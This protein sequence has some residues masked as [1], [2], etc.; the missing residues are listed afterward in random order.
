VTLLRTTSRRTFASLR[1]H[2]NYRLFFAG[3]LT[4]VA[5]TWMQNIAL[6]WLV[7]QLSPHSRGLA[8]ALLTVC[9]FG[10]FTILGLFAGVVTDRLDNRKTVIVTQIVQMVFSA[11]LAAITLLGHT[12]L[13][14][15][16]AI[17]ALTGTAVVFDTPSR[18]NLTFQMVGRDELPNAIALNSSLFNTAR[19]FGP[20]LAG[21]LIAAVGVGWCFAINAASFLAVLAA[22]LAMRTA[23]L[24]PLVD[25]RRP[26][27]WRGTREGLRYARKNRTVFVT[28]SMMVVFASICFNFNI[29]L[30]LLAKNTL[31]AG[32][33]TFGVI[34]AAFGAGAL[35]GA[36][37]AATIANTRWRFMLLGAAG[38]GACELFIAPVHGVALAAALLFV[39]GAF[40]TSYTANS[41]SAIQLASPDHIRGR[42][43]GLYYYAW[44][45]L[46]P[47]GAIIVGWLCD[48]GGTELAFAV[49]GSV[50]LAMTLFGAAAVTRM[51]R[52]VM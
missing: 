34:S 43:L 8:V 10:P 44:N 33:R 17:A 7:L 24:F 11:V 12:Q 28:L 51:R 21:V 3:Q 9:R 48:R 4:S 37:S 16:Y 1:H 39:C 42:V 46:A 49:G 25:R 20:A 19:I 29:L 36:L 30:P 13:W 6:A 22:L 15:V 31:D 35:L 27:M 2:Y 14:E 18:Q 40:F 23:E 32:P 41:N 45:G 38:F 47:F 5:G 26:T 52:V 50:A